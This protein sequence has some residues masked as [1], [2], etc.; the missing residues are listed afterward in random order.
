MTADDEHVP[1]S[2]GERTAWTYAV[3]IP[4][5]TLGYL[6]VV[7]PRALTQPIDQVAWAGPML[8]AMG[9]SIVAS[10]VGAIVFAIV[11]R[12]H[13]GRLDVRDT[14]IE[15]YGDR[16]ALWFTTAGAIV[17]LPLSMLEVDWFWI[18]S[19]LFVLAATGSTWGAI[20][21]IRAHRGTFVG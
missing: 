12:D 17:A 5:G 9:L 4:V 3:V 7:V 20:V 16:V 19:T 6:A 1:P 8:W 11:V 21:Q 2:Y 13:E 18:G 10:I 14:Q 15:R